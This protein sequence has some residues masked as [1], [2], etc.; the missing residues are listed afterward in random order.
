MIVT[1]VGAETDLLVARKF[2]RR[3]PAGTMTDAGRINSEELE[4]RVIV[5]STPILGPFRLTAPF[6]ELPPD[7]VGTGNQTLATE[8]AL[9]VRVPERVEPKV[10]L[11]VARVVVGT[12]V[13][14]MTK[15]A[16]VRPSGTSTAAGTVA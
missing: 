4:A 15:L 14:E 2:A 7:K 16:V 1:G 12:T 9:I 6:V 11:I 5:V 8:G 13:V 10:P 3:L